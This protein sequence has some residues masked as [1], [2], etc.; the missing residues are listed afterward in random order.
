[1]ELQHRR[2]CVR[3]SALQQ[4]LTATSLRPAA[5]SVRVDKQHTIIDVRSAPASVDGR[6]A[7]DWGGIQGLGQICVA[8]ET[9]S[10]AVGF[11]IG[12]G[13]QPGIDV[14]A[15]ALRPLLVGRDATD[16]EGLW[17]AMYQHTLAYGCV[18]AR[19]RARRVCVCVCACVC[20]CVCVCVCV[21]VRA[22]PAHSLTA[23]SVPHTIHN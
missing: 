15:L 18:C 12:G 9:A 2:D 23:Q 5:A 16:V 4:Q 14:I 1:M 17:D 3:L 20:A 6:P 8:V 10:G 19:A 22:C 13:G 7:N 21:C 11:G